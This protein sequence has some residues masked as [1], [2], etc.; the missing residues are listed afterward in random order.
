MKKFYKIT[1]IIIMIPL[2]QN[3][4]KTFTT[5][6]GSD[7]SKVANGGLST[8]PTTMPPSPAPTPTPAPAPTPTPAG[9]S[10]APT[11]SSVPDMVLPPVVSPSGPATPSLYPGPASWKPA[12]VTVSVGVGGRILSGISGYGTVVGEEQRF[13]GEEQALIKADPA[14]PTKL[15]CPA[16]ARQLGGSCCYETTADCIGG[17]WHSDYLYRGVAFGNGRFVAAGGQ[18][19]AISRVSNDGF[20]WSQKYNLIKGSGLVTGARD[21]AYWMGG[22]AFGNGRFVAVGGHGHLYW[23][24]DGE[25][26]TTTSTAA[27]GTYFRRIEFIGDRFF[28]TGD[29]GWGFTT[30]GSQWDGQGKEGIKPYSIHLIGDAYYGVAGEK[31]YKLAKADV[32]TNNWQEVYAYTGLSQLG[33]NAVTKKYFMMANGKLLTSINIAGPWDVTSYLAWQIGRASIHSGEY[34]VGTG[35]WSPDNGLT[36]KGSGSPAGYTQPIIAIVSGRVK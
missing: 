31:L 19:H 25:H 26:W 17:G 4:G 3:C 15:I 22:V 21:Q 12:L 6:D 27:T 18:G 7:L 14:D 24:V 32:N 1:S 36:W 33:Y 16:P 11:T 10:P 35:T 23:S 8:T 20:A 28:A 9:A 5:G 2:F 29:S 13:S 30:D 34:H